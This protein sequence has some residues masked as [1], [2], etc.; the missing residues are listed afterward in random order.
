MGSGL[1]NELCAAL[2][3]SELLMASPFELAR[4]LAHVRQL[5]AQRHVVRAVHQDGQDRLRRARV[6]DH[7]AGEEDAVG[8]RVLGNGRRGLLAVVLEQED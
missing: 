8:V 7:L 6:L 5:V 1:A 2:I 3:F 4:E